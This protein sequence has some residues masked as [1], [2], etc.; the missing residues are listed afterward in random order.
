MPILIPIEHFENAETELETSRIVDRVVA[1]KMAELDPEALALY[2]ESKTKELKTDEDFRIAAEAHTKY[3]NA[4]NAQ[5][6][7]IPTAEEIL[8]QK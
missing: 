6:N 8:K 3:L 1:E 7:K 4:V 2:I 5:G